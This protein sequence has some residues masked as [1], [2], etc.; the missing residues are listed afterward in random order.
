MQTRQIGGMLAVAIFS[1]WILG[2]SRSQSAKATAEQLE[3]S[4]E[5]VDTTLKQQV[6]QAGSALQASNYTDAIL[7]MNQVA[8]TQ[9]LDEAQKKAIGSVISQTR[10]A[11]HHNPHLDNPQLY[12]ALSELTVRAHGEN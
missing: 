8:Q 6:A 1:V 4:Y 5:K 9:A 11:L 10:Q 7:I 3:K 12:K 2:C